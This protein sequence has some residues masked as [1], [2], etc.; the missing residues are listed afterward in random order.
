MKVYF[1]KIKTLS[2]HTAAQSYHNEH[3]SNQQ[4]RTVPRVTRGIVVERE[5]DLTATSSH[6]ESSKILT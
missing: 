3:D 1:N 4:H 2:R 6:P 5:A